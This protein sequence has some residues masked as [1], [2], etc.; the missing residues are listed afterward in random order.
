MSKKLVLNASTK[1]T[2]IIDNGH[3]A[4]AGSPFAESDFAIEVVLIPETAKQEILRTF[5]SAKRGAS[6]TDDAGFGKAYL[7]KSIVGWQGIALPEDPE[8]DAE[9]TRE[10]IH[11][12]YET[13][14]PFAD[15]VI[16]AIMDESEEA[17]IQREN[18]RK[19]S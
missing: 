8:T 13:C 15:R 7:C 17:C 6:R 18:A 3:E 11:R 5:T 10:N 16:R 4:F 2:V 19:N 14:F 12:M 9:C 1:K